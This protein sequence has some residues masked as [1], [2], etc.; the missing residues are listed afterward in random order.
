MRKVSPHLT[1][2]LVGLLLFGLGQVTALQQAT[3]AAPAAIPTAFTYQGRLLDGT[4]PANGSYAMTFRLYNA[5]SGGAQVGTAINQTVNVVDGLFTTQLDFGSAAFNGNQRWLSIEVAGTLLTPRQA[6]TA[7]PYALYSTAA[8]WSGL[9]GVPA[10]F[11]D[12][13]DNNTTYT[14][15]TGLALSGTQFRAEGSPYANVIVVAKSGGDFTSVQ[16]ALDS[17]ADAGADNPYLVYVAPG[18]Y[19]EQVVLKPY[20]T[21]EGAGEGATIIRWTGGSQGPVYGSGSATLIGADNAVI[22]HLTVESNGTGQDNAVAIYNNAASPT[23]SN[24]TAIAWNG[25][26]NY[27]IYNYDVSL[28]RI[29]DVTAIA[30]GGTNTYGVL[31]Y[32]SSSPEM[33]N[34]RVTGSGGTDYNIGI[35]NIS[36]SSPEISNAAITASGGQGS[37]GI[38]NTSASPTIRE[39]RIRGGTNSIYKG[40]SGAAKVSNS[41]LIGSIS[42]GLI[43]FDNYDANLAAIT[44]P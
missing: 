17:I 42:S 22:R 41:Q 11:A 23:L 7:V 15:G 27:G 21:L 32:F 39:S 43:C 38:Y 37:Y 28:P 10:G 24:V 40:G 26:Y 16:A 3:P 18:V 29:S 36:S 1:A 25:A 33:R 2:V 44:C 4:V 34:V 6:L 31:N 8:P 19:I 5:A 35:Y 30:S 13:V 12:G 9:S 20:V 14:A